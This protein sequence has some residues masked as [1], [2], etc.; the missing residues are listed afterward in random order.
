MNDIWDRSQVLHHYGNKTLSKL[1][2]IHR[3]GMVVKIQQSGV[4]RVESLLGG[5][6]ITDMLVFRFLQGDGVAA[7]LGGLDGLWR[8]LW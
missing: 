7:A 5:V 4:V 3:E 8:A 2:L 6:S 1:L